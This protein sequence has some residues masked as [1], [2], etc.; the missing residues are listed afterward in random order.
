M[1]DDILV[2]RGAR[3][4]S[5]TEGNFTSVVTITGSMEVFC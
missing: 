4:I 1:V 3:I 5:V 2:R